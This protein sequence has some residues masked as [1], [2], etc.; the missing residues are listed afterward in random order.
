MYLP[1]HFNNENRNR[2]FD[3]Y[4]PRFP[5][6][7]MSAIFYSILWNF[8][9]TPAR[10]CSLHPWPWRCS[11]ETRSNFFVRYLPAFPANCLSAIFYYILRNFENSPAQACSLHSW[12]WRCL[13][14]QAGVTTSLHYP[15]PL[16]PSAYPAGLW[17]LGTPT[18]ISIYT[19]AGKCWLTHLRGYAHEER[20]L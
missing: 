11:C 17:K 10:A 16:H 19:L 5:A 6:N 14:G 4:L 12:P 13:S 18:P 2:F 15:S 8:E 9:F 7:C 3:R 20:R 1:T